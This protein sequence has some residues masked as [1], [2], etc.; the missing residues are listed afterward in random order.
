MGIFSSLVKFFEGRVGISADAKNKNAFLTFLVSRGINAKV[1][2]YGNGGIYTEISPRMV[3]NIAP[4]LDKLNIMVYINNI[5][6]FKRLSSRYAGRYGLLTGA[7]LF[8]LFLWASTFF[9]WRVDIVGAEKLSR[10]ETRAELSEMGVK[11]G[12]L[13]SNIDRASAINSFLTEHPEISWAALNFKGTTAVLVLRET[14]EKPNGEIEESARL[15]VAAE[16]GVV[17]SVLVYEGTALVKVGAPVKRGD[18]LVSGL[19]SGSGLQI[20]DTPILKM[21]NAVGSVRADVTRTAEVFIPFYEHFTEYESGEKR[22]KEFSVFGHDFSFGKTEGLM[23]ESERHIT[24]F[25]VIE[26][27]VTVRTYSEKTEKTV[28]V[29]RVSEE[30]RLMAEALLYERIS[31]VVGDGELSSVKTTF[32]ES[33]DGWTAGA[34]M[35][36]TVEIAVPYE[37]KLKCR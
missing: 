1:V 25:G 4:T 3:K 19:I 22:A 6:G 2:P 30:A 5:Y 10:E 21:S 36:C 20:T 35:S 9:V 8:V 37:G 28:T 17:R 16:D 33:E 23:L 34:E 12:A 7:I 15:L 13:I 31:E 11:V 29:T 24:F 14:E 32:T 26:I 27:P 18:L